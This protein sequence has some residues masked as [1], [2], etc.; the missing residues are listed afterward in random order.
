MDIRLIPPATVTTTTLAY[1]IQSGRKL[2]QPNPDISAI[3]ELFAEPGLGYALRAPRPS[4]PQSLSLWWRCGVFLEL[5]TTK[6]APTQSGTERV[7]RRRDDGRPRRENSFTWCGCGRSLRSSVQYTCHLGLDETQE[8]RQCLVLA[9]LVL[10]P[11]GGALQWN[12]ILL[13]LWRS[14]SRL[15]NQS[16]IFDV[17]CSLV[18]RTLSPTLAL[19][20]R[21]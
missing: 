3:C 16:T 6:F 17:L 10:D 15:I 2:A 4:S 8:T 11:T 7:S 20:K 13:L 21:L 9:S 12:T 19:P 5:D 14:R 18:S 1:F